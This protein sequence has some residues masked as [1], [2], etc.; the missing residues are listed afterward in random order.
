MNTRHG[1]TSLNMVHFSPYLSHWTGLNST[2]TKRQ[3]LNFHQ[4][5]RD[6]ALHTLRSL[7]M[8]TLVISCSPRMTDTFASLGTGCLFFCNHVL[9]DDFLWS[10]VSPFFVFLKFVFVRR[11]RQ[12]NSRSFPG[13]LMFFGCSCFRPKVSGTELMSEGRKTTV[14]F[15][16]AGGVTVG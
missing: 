12:N 14:V 16:E 8:M 1:T 7:R 13:V 9:E 2:S 15:C 6:W 11:A 5:L 4:F 3:C 10:L